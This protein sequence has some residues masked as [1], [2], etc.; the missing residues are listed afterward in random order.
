MNHYDL[1]VIGGGIVGLATAYQ[2]LRQHPEIRLAIVEKEER[3]ARHQTGHN[4]GVI[5]RGIYYRPGSL[6]AQNCVRGVQALLDFCTEQ[7]IPYEMCG[8][9][10]V[11]TK[12]EE[13]PRLEEL[14]RRGIA[15]G[16]PNLE[17]IGP[18]RLREIEPHCEG[19]QALYS[20]ETGIVDYVQVAEAY[21]RQV[22]RMGGEIFL[23]EEVRSLHKEGDGCRVVGTRIELRSRAV[24]NCAGLHADRVAKM[25]NPEVTKDRIVPFR[26]E[27]YQLRS[28]AQKLVNGLIY[29]VPD[30]AFP[31]LGVHLTKTISGMIEAG[32]NAVLALAREGYEK[33]TV[34]GHDLCDVLGFP[35]FWR[36]GA[37]YWKTGLYEVYRSFSKRAFL[38]SLQRFVPE[39]S[40]EDLCKGGSGVR[41]Q[42]LTQEGTLIDDFAITEDGSLIHVLSAPSPGA[43]ASL[44]IGEHLA[45]R[46]MKHFE[47]VASKG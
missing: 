40:K 31:F 36:M 26:G 9:V 43:T 19:I 24:L 14:Q 11:A 34:D 6:K 16:V 41:S 4:S 25:A 37:K 30:P 28:E 35:G 39:L 8:K 10:I 46:C 47:M 45:S 21:A 20:P 22:A 18:E 42:L 44:A 12:R 38:K 23:G 27:Y 13:L 32:P 2:L 17:M 5:H 3:V 33:T 7:Q 15:N 29:P 1:V